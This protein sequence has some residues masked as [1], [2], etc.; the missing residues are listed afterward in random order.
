M[1]FILI[2]TL[3]FVFQSFFPSEIKGRTGPNKHIE[4]I[5]PA[6]G[7]SIDCTKT[8]SAKKVIFTV[9]GSSVNLKEGEFITMF[10]RSNEAGS[11]IRISKSLKVVQ[12]YS[13]LWSFNINAEISR[14]CK[15]AELVAFVS[16][17]EI[18]DHELDNERIQSHQ[19]ILCRSQEGFTIMAQ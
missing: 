18:T 6:R 2:F 10:L 4:I 3:F 17:S 16:S 12:D 7:S 1:R 5:I 14:K 13:G 15:I 11:W 19:D 9:K 8:K